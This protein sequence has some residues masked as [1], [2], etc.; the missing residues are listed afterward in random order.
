[1]GKKKVLSFTIIAFITGIMLSIQFQTVQDPV[2]RDTRDTKQLRAALEKE[3][4][5]QAELIKELKHL[6]RLNLL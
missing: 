5:L 2:V 1:M 3:K 6:E 4:E